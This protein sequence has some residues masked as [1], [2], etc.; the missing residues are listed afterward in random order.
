MARTE[1]KTFQ[2]HPDDAQEQ[3][4]LYQKFHWSLLSS[5]DVKTVDNSL[6]QRGDS[7]Y[8]VRSSEH[9]VKL[10]FSRDLDTPNLNEIKKLEAGYHALCEPECCEYP[11]PEKSQAAGAG[12]GWAGL[13]LLIGCIVGYNTTFGFGLT[14]FIIGIVIGIVLSIILHKT[15]DAP[16]NAAY[17]EAHKEEC[18]RISQEH[19]QN[20]QKFAEERR[21]IWSELEKYQ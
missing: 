11:A 21:R 7:I 3:I 13:G 9:Y 17:E 1:S 19:K 18:A 14:I 4:D 5:Q 2:C 20:M 10:T 15:I 8:N 6:E 16:K 12:C